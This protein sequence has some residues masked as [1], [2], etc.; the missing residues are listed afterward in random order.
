ME[1]STGSSIDVLQH[2]SSTPDNSRNQDLDAIAKRL[3]VD[4]A[5]RVEFGGGPFVWTNLATVLT[6]VVKDG[7]DP[8]QVEQLMFIFR[9]IRNS[10]AGVSKNQ[11]QARVA[12]LPKLIQEVVSQ[13][14]HTHYGNAGYI[15]MLRA[16]VQAL[17]N[18]LTG[19]E[20][21]KDYIWDSFLVQIPSPSCDQNLLSTL[22][23]IEDETIVLSTVMLCYN[24]VFESHKR[25]ALLFSTKAG[26]KLLKQLMIESH[27]TSAKEDRKSFEMT[28]TLINHLIEQDF[29]EQ[30][31][32]A[33]KEDEIEEVEDGETTGTTK[34][35]P[36]K[37]NKVLYLSQEQ[38]TLLKMIF[39]QQQQQSHDT[40]SAT[41]A[42]DPFAVD[43]TDPPVNLETTDFLTGIFSKVSALTIEVFKGLD[44][45]GVGEHSVEDLTN[46]S[47]GLMLLL[48]C[49]AHLS[50]HEDGQVHVRSK[51]ESGD[52][53]VEDGVDEEIEQR[54]EVVPVPNWFKAQHM[55]MVNGGLVESAVELLR[56]ADV[57][58]A[59][60]S[61]PVSSSPTG[62]PAMAANAKSTVLSNT[63]TA[64]GQDS[65]FVGLKRDIVKLIGNLA[66]RSRHVQDRIRNCNGLIVM[67]SQCNIDDANPYLREY[68]ILAMK[69]ILTGNAEN[70]ALIEELQPIAA[71]DHPAL[72]E[73]RITS[74]LDAETGRSVLS[75]HTPLAM[76]R[77]RWL[78]PQDPQFCSVPSIPPV[79]L[80]IKLEVRID[81]EESYRSCPYY[82][83]SYHD[84]RSSLT[85][86][87]WMLL[88]NPNLLD[89][90]VSGL[91]FKDD[92]DVR[93]FTTALS[94]LTRLTT[95]ELSAVYWKGD[96][97]HLGE[98]IVFC[99]PPTLSVL[100]MSLKEYE[101]W[102][103]LTITSLYRYEA[104]GCLQPWG[105]SDQE[106]GLPTTPVRNEEVLSNLRVL[107]FKE[108]DEVLSE[109]ELRAITDHCPNVHVLVMPTVGEVKETRLLA[110]HV[111]SSCSQ[112]TNL[113]H[114]VNPESMQLFELMLHVMKALPEGQVVGLFLG[115]PFVRGSRAGRSS[116]LSTT[117]MYIGLHSFIHLNGCRNANGKALQ[118]VLTEFE[119][120]EILEAPWLGECNVLCIHLDDAIEYDWVCTN[121]R[122]LT[123]TVG[124]P[125]SPL[126]RRRDDMGAYY[127][128]PPS[129]AFSSEEKEQLS[130]LEQL[131]EQIGR[132]TDLELLSAKAFFYD[133]NKVWPT[134]SDYRVNAFPGLMSVGDR[135]RGRPG[136][137]RHLKGLSKLKQSTGSVYADTRE[138]RETMNWMEVTWINKY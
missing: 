28:Y 119:A 94:G 90:D 46:L 106:C 126:F 115:R 30:L 60:V 26:R 99:C 9:I 33:L 132:L 43:E 118:V 83:P 95:F 137:L 37:N 102:E 109:M 70:Q 35:S 57:S 88:V 87:C 61:K 40:P 129:F 42:Y 20:V 11:D 53:A 48:G 79:T 130:S 69:N 22:A 76:G 68:A 127:S 71:V 56:Q 3:Q 112:L 8:E 38:V 54:A 117:L 116:K 24:F 5:F 75:Q 138:T 91:A 77:P 50:L 80:L 84:P 32:E 21:S 4:A 17:S 120:L 44:K 55:N 19:N 136:Y 135:R 74:K 128:R 110:E 104:P 58:L 52:D 111:A 10:A 41:N 82:L 18:L 121:M 96:R 16:G 122:K 12:G 101:L 108:M 15:M 39:Q 31:Y 131:Y 93:L 92:R 62:S 125:D 114:Q 25:S 100:R 1:K 13:A 49:F 27:A 47:S 78:A 81:R 105:W 2:L 133:V 45:G 113:S 89:V 97:M 63:S 103:D 23:A 64:Q 107:A 98:A 34:S 134:A 6:R 72:Q 124:I 123:I 66:Y 86:L 67:L 14:A 85:Q 29:I 65:F 51:V 7:L 73:A 36:K 59:R